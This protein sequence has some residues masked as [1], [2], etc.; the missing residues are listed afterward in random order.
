MFKRAL[1]FVLGMAS[2][3][4]SPENRA[5]WITASKASPLSVDAAPYPTPLPN[6]VVI[7]SAAVAINPVDWKIQAWGGFG[8]DYP[9]ILGEDVAGEIVE[10]GTAVTSVKVGDR[11]LAYTQGIPNKDPRQ[12]AFQLYVA[13]FAHL[14]T[15]IPDELAFEDAAVFPLG[16]ATAA[17]GLFQK[18]HL[19]LPLPVPKAEAAAV[20]AESSKVVLVWGGSSSVGTS[21]IQLAVA[22]GARV[23]TT[24]S[25]RNHDYVKALGAEWAF[26]YHSE[27]VVADAT[28]ALAGLELVGVYDA[29]ADDAGQALAVQIIKQ[30]AG[31]GSDAKIVS[32][33]GTQ[34]DTV[35]GVK[36][37]GLSSPSIAKNEVGG[38]IFN[39]FLPQAIATKQ[40]LP[41]PDAWVIAEGLEGVQKGLDANREGVSAKKVVIKL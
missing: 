30:L 9:H 22:A 19:S 18:T 2:I 38:A 11:V 36:I 21:A 20:A 13:A 33:R 39:D 6:E 14:T 28:S 31:E 3:T 37:L 27:S 7:K 25:E 34:N 8:L 1:Q 16:I 5:A 23:A 24:A 15:K 41:K 32:V 17:A 29:I 4:H 35:D 10:V 26:D 12:G 40:V